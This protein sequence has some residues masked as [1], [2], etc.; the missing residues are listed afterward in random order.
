MKDDLDAV[1]ALTLKDLHD[2][3]AR[4]PLTQ[5]TTVAIGPLGELAPPR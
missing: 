2:V 1:E 4:W 5:S 3:L